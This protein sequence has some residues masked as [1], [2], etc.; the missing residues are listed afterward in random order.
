M[1]RADLLFNLFAADM[2]AKLAFGRWV[3]AMDTAGLEAP[4][5]RQFNAERASADLDV[6]R[7]IKDLQIAG[8]PRDQWIRA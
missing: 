4:E 7:A 3:F 2:A 5:T 1:D 8:V 6:E